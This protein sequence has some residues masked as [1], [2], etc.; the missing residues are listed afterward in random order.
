MKQ[1]QE[2]KSYISKPSHQY[3]TVTGDHILHQQTLA[4]VRNSYRRPHLTS[5][6]PRISM[7]QLQ[8]TTSY[9]SKPSHQ[10]ETVTR[11]QVLHQQTLASVR[12]SYRRP[13][14]TS[15]NPRISTK[16]LQETTSYISKPSHQHETVTRDHILHQQTLASV[17]NSYR[18]PHL[19]SANPRSSMKQL[20]ETTSYIS[21]PSQQYETVTGDHI[22]HQLTLAAV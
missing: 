2:T 4:S 3:E 15:A 16:Q 21:K 14:L 8:E 11:D 7:K 13:H 12:N 1:L 20:Q 22:L 10:H 9:I 6:N 17:R 19:T 18:R 5:A